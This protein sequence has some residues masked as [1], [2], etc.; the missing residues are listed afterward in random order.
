MEESLS[1]DQF[2]SVARDIVNVVFAIYTNHEKKDILKALAVSVFRSTFDILDMVKDEHGGEVKGFADEMIKAWSPY[3]LETMKLPPVGGASHDSQQQPEQWR[4]LMALKLQVVKTLMKIRAVFP[5]LLLPQSPVLFSTT[6]EELKM[7][8]G[9][10]E[11]LYIKNDVQGRL[12]DADGLPY[13][14]DFLVLEDLDFLQSCIRASPVQR[15]LESQ[16][17][18][19]SNVASTPWVMDVMMLAVAYAQVPNE[20]ELL[21]DIDVNLFLAEETSVTANYNARAACG[22]LLIKL[23]EWLHQGA[24]EGLLAYTKVLFEDANSGWRKREAALFLLTQLMNDFIDVDRAVAPEL[25]G[26]L[27]SFYFYSITWNIP[28]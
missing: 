28:M 21:W 4:G 5:A 8:T 7:L 9:W 25:I 1:E 15:E 2:F 17:Q 16:L 19:N 27:I 3:F 18:L 14:L 11:E 24:L 22:D 13:T 12:E 20:E 26:K 10:Y 6:W 23:G